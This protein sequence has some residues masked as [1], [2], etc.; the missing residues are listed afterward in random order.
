MFAYR[1]KIKVKPY[2][3]E[4]FVNSI[5]SLLRS[6]R[7]AKGCLDFSVYQDSERENAYLGCV[8]RLTLIIFTA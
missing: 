3:P 8:S 6:I 1:L 2:K 5:R 7:K 4:E